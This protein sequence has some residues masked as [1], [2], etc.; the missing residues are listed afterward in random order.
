MWR[1]CAKSA[2]AARCCSE[3][4]GG[5]REF[6]RVFSF[7][8]PI[9]EQKEL[10]G[11][12]RVKVSLSFF[13]DEAGKP[14]NHVVAERL[15]ARGQARRE[16]KNKTKKARCGEKI[17]GSVCDMKKQRAYKPAAAS[18]CC[19]PWQTR[20]SDGACR[21]ACA[22]SLVSVLVGFSTHASRTTWSDS[23]STWMEPVSANG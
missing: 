13:Y 15:E 22:S 9:H 19:T 7:A 20:A 4:Q 17:L 1:G 8:Q 10:N 16:G 5:P 6:G 23:S 3:S 14:L 18:T 11:R 21:D 2:A 12:P